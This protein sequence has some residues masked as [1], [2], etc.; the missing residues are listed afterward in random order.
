MITL[1]VQHYNGSPLPQTLAVTLDEMGGTIGRADTNHLVLPDP[2]RTISRV[3]AQIVYRHGAYWVVDRGSNPIQLNGR[4]LGSGQE[5]AIAHGDQLE[6]GGYV[7]AV[8][9]TPV[10]PSEPVFPQTFGATPTHSVAPGG[11]PFADFSGLGGAAAP[12][13]A[14]GGLDPMAVFGWGNPAGSQPASS[15]PA[16]PAPAGSGIPEDWDPF[17]APSSAVTDPFASQ[18]TPMLASQ[19]VGGGIPGLPTTPVPSLDALF[20]LDAKPLGSGPSGSIFESSVHAANTSTQADPLQS[21]QMAPSVTQA[22]VADHVSALHEPF[23]AAP[24]ARSTSPV[25]EESTGVEIG[26]PAAQ[27]APN[28]VVLSWDDGAQEGRTVIRAKAK[29]RPVQPETPAQQIASQPVRAATASPAASYTV[30][31]P[32]EQMP[33]STAHVTPEAR[34]EEAT[35]AVPDFGDTNNKALLAALEQ[36]LGVSLPQ[37]QALTPEL[38]RLLGSLLRDATQGTVDLLVA[39][40]AV[41]R[42]VRA[43]VT[44]IA[45]KENNPL[46]FSPSA[47]VALNHLLSAPVRGFMP[48][49]LAMQD[50]YDDLRAHQFAFVAG[51]KAALD[52][53]LMRFDPQHLEGKLAQKSGLSSFLMGSRK[54]RMW[55]LFIDLYA[56]ISSEAADDFHELFGKEFLRAYETHLDQLHNEK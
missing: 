24:S 6:I 55:E 48:A 51:M 15:A 17:A 1:T 8:V 34:K 35:Q 46:K 18:S 28:N 4:H 53:V 49:S 45:A 43:E 5:A 50:A 31:M 22:P 52:G 33:L 3:H 38:M 29:V 27:A 26:A 19:S 2:E 41:K 44:M 20:A 11:D 23:F 13:R 9:S 54:A 30:D 10:G 37:N 56:Q 47:E 36:G 39:R 40:A 16:S 14:Q 25:S 32:L 12:D 7:L 42:E 21:L